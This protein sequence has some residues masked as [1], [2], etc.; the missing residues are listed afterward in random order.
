M[1]RK[2]DKPKR[3]AVARVAYE[4]YLRCGGEHGHDIE[5]W[6]AAERLLQEEFN[7]RANT[8]RRPRVAR[9]MEDKSRLA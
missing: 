8:V 1:R 5:D 9:R 2:V 7:R 4:L 3:A 6:L